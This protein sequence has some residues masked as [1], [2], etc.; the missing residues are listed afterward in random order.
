[1]VSPFPLEWFMEIYPQLAED[2]R[3]LECTQEA[4]EVISVPTGWWHMVLNIE[5]KTESIGCSS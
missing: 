2:Q 4:G 1:M 5:G 3:P